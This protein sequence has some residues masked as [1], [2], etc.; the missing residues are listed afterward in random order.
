MSRKLKATF[1][2]EHDLI[3]FLFLHE[4]HSPCCSQSGLRLLATSLQY[5]HKTSEI[6]ERAVLLYVNVIASV[7]YSLSAGP[8]S[9]ISPKHI[10]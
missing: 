9:S 2:M 5:P 6:R 10:L 4:N 8:D 7:F 1:N 3:V